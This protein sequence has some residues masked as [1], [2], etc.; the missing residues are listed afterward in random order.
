MDKERIKAFADRVFGDM[1]STMSAGMAYVGVKTG[2]FRTMAG[3]P[4]MTAADLA[5]AAKL[6]PRYVEEWLSGMA[7][8]G[9]LEYDAAARTFRLPDEHAFLLAS[10]GTDH[11][12]GG[13]YLMAPVL[14]RVAPKVAD[15]FEKGGG[16]RFEDFGPDA[17]VG[18]DVMNS[19][20]YEHRLAGYWMKSLPQVVAALEAGGRALDVGCGVGRI[21]IALAKAFPKAEIVG[22]DP[23]AES[24]RQAQAAAQAA[25]LGSRIRFAAQSTR[26]ASAGDGFDLVTAFDCIH[27]FAEPRRTLSEIRALLK[28]E[29]TLFISE[30][31]ASDRLEENFNPVATMYYGFSLFHCMTQSLANGGPGLGTCMGPARLQALLQEAGFSR[32]E[33]LNIRSQVQEFFAARP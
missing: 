2:L 20:T 7:S 26:E 31:R 10:E 28:P 4:P 33:P 8:A 16:V 24:I 19:G 18:L 25:G 6:Q 5:S 27:D 17:V 9:Y 12:V 3:K 30:P 15:A 13:L 21:S 23:D 32:F 14:L 29:G 22:I 1:A 11:F